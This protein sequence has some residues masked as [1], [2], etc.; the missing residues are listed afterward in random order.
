MK[1]IKF[2]SLFLVAVF[3]LLAMTPKRSNAQTAIFVFLF[4]KQV[5]SESFYL[6]LK[7]G[8]HLS[9]ITNLDDAAKYRFGMQF[10]ML[11][12]IVLSDNF[13]IVPEI[14]FLSQK[15]TKNLPFTTSENMYMDSLLSGVAT[16]EIK[17]NCIDVPV[18][19]RYYLSEKFYIG[20]GPY[21]SFVSNVDKLYSN[22]PA[23]YD[24]LYIERSIDY[25][26]NKFDYGLSVE[27]GWSPKRIGRR[28]GINLT[29]KYSYGFVNVM[30]NHPNGLMSNSVIEGAASFPFQVE[31]D[32]KEPEKED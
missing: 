8:G 28:D 23:D 9:T 26:F 1:K 12:N 17:T 22:T 24:E 2:L 11:A 10:G 4:G 5:A 27:L 29:L 7:I 6:S 21:F 15:G 13:L 20:G 3:V 14:S 18:I 19:L 32:P 31:Q 30:K 25:E 16:Y